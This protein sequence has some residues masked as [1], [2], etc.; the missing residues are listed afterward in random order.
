MEPQK[1]PHYG[2]DQMFIIESADMDMSCDETRSFSSKYLMGRLWTI[3]RR[4]EPV[5]LQRRISTKRIS[6]FLRRDSGQEIVEAAL[7]LPLLFFIMLALFWFGRT[8]NI[9]ATLNRAAQEGIQVATRPTC[10]IPYNNAFLTKAQV[11]QKITNDLQ[12]DHLD[13]NSLT[14]YAPPFTCSATPAPVCTTTAQNIQICTGVP[15]TC[16]T[17][18][19]QVPPVACGGNPVLGTR[20]S[21]GYQSLSPLNMTNIAHIPPLPFGQ[22]LRANRKTEI[23]MVFKWYRVHPPGPWLPHGLGGR[24]EITLSAD[25]VTT[26]RFESGPTMVPWARSLEVWQAI[27][28][29]GLE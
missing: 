24:S 9:M 15:L 16:G 26:S 5:P 11:V 19:C 12:A 22:A 1:L 3:R 14:A 13:P 7:V 23:V 2:P 20:V 27:S 4:G 18:P 17:L 25:L 8:F 21:F 6:L 29:S 28:N 10:A